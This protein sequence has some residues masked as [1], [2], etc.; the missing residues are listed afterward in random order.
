MVVFLMGACASTYGQIKQTSIPIGNAVNKA[1]KK[2]SLTGEDA[3]PFHIRV[4][5]SEPENP[6]S[7]YQGSIEEWWVS[8]NQWRR[9]VTAKGGMKQTVVVVDG[10][11]T[12]RDEGDYYPLW[13]RGYEIALFDPIPDAAAW[14]ASGITIDQ[15]TMPNG[16]KSD[17]CARAKSKIGTGNRAT[18]AF[19]NVCFDDE[20]RLKFI[21]NPRFSMEFHDY[22]GFGKK[23][24]ARKLANDPEPGTALV[25]EVTLLEGGTA[26]MQTALFTPLT[27][28]DERFR[29]ISVSAEQLEQ[30]TANNLPVAWPPVHSGNVRGSLGMYIS[31]D[32]E[33]QVREAWPLNAD[34][35]GLEDP[36]RDQVRQWKIKPV[37]DA[38][39]NPVQIDGGL[40]FSFETVIGDPLPVLSNE[41]ARQLAIYVV[42][43]KLPSHLLPP[44][45]RY[46]VKVSVN[47]QG[48][49][50]GGAEGDTEIPGT[51]KAP[52]GMFQ[53][54]TALFEWR[55]NPL[56][57]NGKAQY[58]QAEL[59]FVAQ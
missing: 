34:N 32:T 56:I 57:R 29:T 11:K 54:M 3:R 47:E 24:I 51:I 8:Q 38:A 27:M 19:S 12:E 30:L 23:Q 6:Q 35:A 48:K 37:K 36:A 58:F 31:I 22:R 49:V 55:F 45:T 25:G 33:G 20:G 26:W 13:L 40:G 21:G 28:N 18:D 15:I 7:P 14:T 59:V 9:E 39:G 46:R 41:E 2:V 52:G 5:I 42:E 17:V 44:G 50:T 10:K 43:P 4:N 16:A 1:L 53:I